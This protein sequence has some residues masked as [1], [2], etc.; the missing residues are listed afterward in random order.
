MGD[1]WG[2]K[3]GVQARAEA[4]E[5]E[6]WLVAECD[7]LRGKESLYVLLVTNE[8]MATLSLRRLGAAKEAT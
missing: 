2:A 4:G 5:A 1:H 8:R 6:S 7:H 3:A